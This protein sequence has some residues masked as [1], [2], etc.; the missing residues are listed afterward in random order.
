VD[1][2]L[3]IQVL[4]NCAAESEQEAQQVI[5]LKKQF[6][7]SQVLQTLSARLSKDHQFSFQQSELQQAAVYST[8]R[9]VLKEIMTMEIAPR[10]EAVSD[11]KSP[12]V[13]KAASIA[14]SPTEVQEVKKSSVEIK[15]QSS[16][17]LSRAVADKLV[18]YQNIEKTIDSV[19]VADV[20]LR[21]LKKLS[22]LKH[23]FEMLFTEQS[24]NDGIATEKQPATVPLETNE[25]EAAKSRR[26]K[27]IALAKS[28]NPQADNSQP[29][30]VR[31]KRKDGTPDIIEEIKTSKEEIEPGNDRLK[32]Q[33]EIID[34]FIKTQPSIASV[35]E[36]NPLPPTDLNSI[37]SGEFGE[38][39]VSETLVEIL[40]KQGK[41]DRA[42]EV[43]KKLIWKYPQKKA[44]FASQIEDLKK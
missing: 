14:Q 30:L 18:V 15:A 6:P 29:S 17:S 32:E 3:L 1:K 40:I 5:A 26:E 44:Y 25:P 28:M 23:N 16:P 43:L 19:D 20:V 7:Y 2:K 10:S 9:G 13:E 39:I 36:R 21:D 31:K 42:I 38:N 27:I 4:G 12:A 37:K 35:R 24:A 34:Q 11:L 33:I 41:K 22:Q 8:D